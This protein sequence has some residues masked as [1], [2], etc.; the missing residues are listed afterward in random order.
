M[1]T[2]TL[3]CNSKKGAI[4]NW[5]T[6][7]EVERLLVDHIG[8]VVGS[9]HQLREEAEWVANCTDETVQLSDKMARLSSNRH[10]IRWNT[11]VPSYQRPVRFRWHPDREVSWWRRRSR[12][13]SEPWYGR[14]TVD[15]V[16]E[17]YSDTAYIIDDLF[18]STKIYTIYILFAQ[19]KTTNRGRCKCEHVFADFWAR[20]LVE[21]RVTVSE[22]WLYSRHP[23]RVDHSWDQV[24]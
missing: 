19:W 20:N 1:Y 18:M 9:D 23:V 12:S 8:I 21:S 2:K 7:G 3:F 11:Q 24:N 13:R 14:S 22:D 6:V 16:P 10:S 5:S 4:L 17:G 15:L